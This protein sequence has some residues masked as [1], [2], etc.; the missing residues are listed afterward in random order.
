M[1]CGADFIDWQR[2]G[3]QKP[4]NERYK[5]EMLRREWIRHHFWE[6]YRP[7]QHETNYARRKGTKGLLERAEHVLRKNVFGTTGFLNDIQTSYSGVI[8]AAQHATATCCRKCIEYWH[9]IP[10]DAKP[11]D[12]QITYLRDW[13][14]KFIGD[15]FPNIT[16]GGEKVPPIK[17]KG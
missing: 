1:E 12:R 4:E 16:D 6:H 8:P 15:K 7:S 3:S 17:Q 14:M 11:T 5:L 9:D 10:R 13:I 2:A